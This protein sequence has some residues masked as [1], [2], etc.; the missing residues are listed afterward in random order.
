MTRM[1]GNISFPVI[2]RFPNTVLTCGTLADWEMS[3]SEG[4]S[5]GLGRVESGQNRT[6]TVEIL[7]TGAHG[8]L[9]GVSKPKNGQ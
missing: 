8:V 5:P 9:A 1:Y 6:L 4:P 3:A 7:G 2:Q